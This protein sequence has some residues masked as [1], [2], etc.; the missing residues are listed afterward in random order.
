MRP[1]NLK[2]TNFIGIRK[3]LKR[4]SI[5]LDF[6]GL[7]GLVALAGVNG[8]GKTTVLDNMHPY[9]L[10]PFR[11]AGYSP[12]QFSYYEETYGDAKKDL[13]W[14]HNGVT[15]RSE[16]N[17]KGTN[18]TKKTEAFLYTQTPDGWIPVAIEDGT[19]SDGKTDTYDACVNALLGSPDMFFTAAFAAQGRKG[20]SDYAP[21]DIK[22]L[23]SELLGLD[24]LLALSKQA[25]EAAKHQAAKL[26]GMQTRLREHTQALADLAAA[27]LANGIASAQ[28]ETATADRVDA[29]NATSVA[30]QALAEAN[31]R[32]STR[33]DLLRRRSTVQQQIKAVDVEI[34]NLNRTREDELN[35]LRGE[36]AAKGL[37]ADEQTLSA[38]SLTL[39]DRI[40]S[41][42]IRIAAAPDPV[43]AAE[44]LDRLTREVADL[45]DKG[46]AAETARDADASAVSS[47]SR[48][49]E[50]LT[51][52]TR[53]ET[54]Q[55]AQIEALRT[56]GAL[57]D[58]VPCVGTEMN[59]GCELLKNA[60][61]SKSEA[62]ALESA[63]E[64]TRASLTEAKNE[65][66]AV[67]IRV[68][69]HL[70]AAGEATQLKASLVERDKQ[71]A[72]ARKVN[73]R[74]SA[75]AQLEVSAN[76]AQADLDRNES[77][78]AEKRT[79]ISELRADVMRRVDSCK[80]DSE[81]ALQT[82][83]EYRLSLAEE[84]AGIPAD[85]GGAE[86]LS[87]AQ[88]A[89][90]DADA[91]LTDADRR[92]SAAQS[93]VASTAERIKQTSS[94]VTAG[95]EAARMAA[96]ISED[97]AHWKMLGK[98]LGRDGIV[99]LSID[100]AGPAI[101]NFANE[102]LIACYGPRFSLRF[103]TQAESKTGVMKETFDIRVF[104]AETDD[105][106]SVTKTSGGE[107]IWI[108]E[109]LTR[110]IAL[111]KAG[112][113][114]RPYQALFSDE[115]DGALDP[116]RKQNFMRMKRRVL[117]IGGYD[118]EFFISHTQELRDMADHVID[119]G[120][121]RAA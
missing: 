36:Y 64:T 106:C 76:E 45:I 78:L 91:A 12:R 57:V 16:I 30:A 88:R 11:A 80:A 25:D 21:G 107:R 40:K 46:A 5:E 101:S 60:H 61:A 82:R 116:D 114:G 33:D 120:A 95:D 98:A 4:D 6:S 75:V 102:L 26:E 108:N 109:A 35:R 100:D 29:R 8:N 34:E 119:L 48:L 70:K 96:T 28:L 113:F 71:L 23:L 68:E 41:L 1:L 32:A 20:L 63:L 42:R 103:D 18:K 84:L 27:E 90:N 24:H 110:A 56:R 74:A 85:A 58:R 22:L 86:D 93:A 89:M 9:R 2:L 15:Y 50:R 115:A 92:I 66:A 73:E 65:L 94:K 104:D 10:M 111:F 54:S 118:V 17:I 55:L 53:T 19:R 59:S 83:R 97:I 52:L 49:T 31:A 62:A 112:Q 72:E 3:G 43:A 79:Q 121:L 37:I 105:D 87:A 51:G 77:A 39:D 14:E 99:A 38:Q 7:T 47:Q 44:T 67:K 69:A 13:L 117:D 81:S